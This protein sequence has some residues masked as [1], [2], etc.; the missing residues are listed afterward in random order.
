MSVAKKSIRYLQSE[1]QKIT[2]GSPD[3]ID[4]LFSESH[5]VSIPKVA[6]D[7][8][9]EIINQMA[10]GRMVSIIAADSE[11]TTQ[12]AADMLNVSRPHI[13][14]LLENGEIPFKKVGAHRRINYEDLLRYD[15]R[16][17]ENRK[18]QLDFLAQEAQELNLGY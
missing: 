5:H 15:Q 17:T 9:I 7:F 4:L 10:Q 2:K 14:K 1:G 16:I 3:T 13:V 8:L 6:Y 11:L 12:Q 18:K